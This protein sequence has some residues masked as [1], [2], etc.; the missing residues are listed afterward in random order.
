MSLYKTIEK[1]LFNTLT[2][3]II[4]NVLFL[5][6]PHVFL[7]FVGAY[8]SDHVKQLI[9]ALAL[10]PEQQGQLE[11]AFSQLLL[12]GGLT[13]TFALLAGLFTI[14]F[15]RHL[16][17]KPIREITQVLRAIKEKDG[18][19]SATLPAYTYDEI[20]DMAAGY[21]DFT[22]RLRQ[23][24]AETRR[25]SVS[26]ALSSTKLQK[27]VTE[28]HESALKQ[29]GQAQQ[30]FLSSSQASQAI[31]EIAGN[32]LR[33][34]EQTSGNMREI[35]TSSDELRKV[36]EQIKSIR[37]LATSFQ[38]TV[39]K[40]SE[41][42]GNITHILSMVKD[43]S[44]QTNLLALNASIEA[45]R[46]GEAGRG[47]A[48][49]ADE[50]RNLSHKVGVATGEI[51]DNIGEMSALVESTYNSAVNILEYVEN[52]ESF[53]DGTSVQ[54]GKLVADFDEINSQLTGI[55]AA[56]DELSYTNKESHNHV[57]Q[58]TELSLGMKE[59]ME[60]SKAF[61]GELEQA[62]EKTQELLSHF[63]IGY[64]AF[65]NI[66][67]T[68]MDW[69]KQVTQTLEQLSSQGINLMDHNYQR[70]NPGQQPE[71]F[72][73]RYTEAYERVM[74]PLFDEFI[75]QRPE[76]IYA[77]C[78]DKNGYAAAHH[79]K[80]SKPMTGD[81]QTDLLN[82]RNRRILF[83]SRTEKRRA[84]HQTPFLLQTI[85]RD[86]GEILN[87]LSIPVYINGQHWGALIMGF[88]PKHLLAD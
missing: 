57:Q 6:L 11:S 14:F 22:D 24:I 13:V 44:D 82:S 20:S 1:N 23:M 59:D 51:D 61:S 21:N 38:T 25:H 58:I 32:T 5:L 70:M 12:I 50:V 74:Q 35:R 69:A 16:F 26:V 41:N 47:F 78:V 45:A 8:Y 79:A 36:L 10:S 27:V 4:G 77:I 63:S 48:V 19:I 46:A 83:G 7:I 84:S 75:R 60:R 42:S 72:L 85:I 65:E 37:E 29:E 34:S 40:L 53:I 54:F 17:L 87:D 31:D 73:T 43:F 86:T 55:S 28:A 3:K 30:V 67:H 56:I 68:G 49:V 18:D 62:T 81:L 52:T 2:K 80:V 88:D 71:K 15:M 64:G 33:I 66:I 39:Q 76:F 9:R